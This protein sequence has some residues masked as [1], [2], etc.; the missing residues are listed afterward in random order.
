[1]PKT[2]AQLV[3]CPDDRVLV[4]RHKTHL[5]QIDTG[6]RQFFGQMMHI[7]VAGPSRQDFIADNKRRCRRIFH[8]WFMANSRI[9]GIVERSAL[10]CERLVL[11]Y[12]LTY[13]GGNRVME[14]NLGRSKPGTADQRRHSHLRGG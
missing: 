2:A 11:Y 6:T 5:Q 13:V 4:I 12:K 3:Y 10:A 14:F 7:G 8:D 1:M 9:L